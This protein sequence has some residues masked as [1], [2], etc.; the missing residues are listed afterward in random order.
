DEVLGA[1]R[2]DLNTPA[3]FGALFTAINSF[4]TRRASKA[5]AAALDV[6]LRVL[7]FD[8]MDEARA[9][10]PPEVQAMA[11][12]RWAAKRAKDFAAAD[13]LRRDL[14]AAGWSMQDGKEAYLLEPLKKA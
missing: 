11:E 12:R 14:A 4:D 5:D 2:S 9:S 13:S 8:R 6:V 10:V 7:G 1:L 3:A